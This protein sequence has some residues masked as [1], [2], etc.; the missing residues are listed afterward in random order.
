MSFVSLSREAPVIVEP[1]ARQ[2]ARMQDLLAGEF[3]LVCSEERLQNTS[4]L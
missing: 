2:F 4:Q 3:S 1:S